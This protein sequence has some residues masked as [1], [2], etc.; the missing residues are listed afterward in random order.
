M[1]TAFAKRSGNYVNSNTAE[2]TVFE[3]ADTKLYNSVAKL[4]P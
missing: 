4:L 2:L 1:L 3:V